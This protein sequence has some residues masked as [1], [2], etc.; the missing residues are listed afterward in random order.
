[1]RY[2]IET[3]NHTTWVTSDPNDFR[4]FFLHYLP[5]QGVLKLVKPRTSGEINSKVLK[6]NNGISL[7]SR[8][9]N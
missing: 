9:K 4:C 3:K 2:N 1:M 6:D 7:E 5:F 8:M